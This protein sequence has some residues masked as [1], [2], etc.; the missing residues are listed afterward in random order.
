LNRII[1]LYL[2]SAQ[3]LMARMDA[4][5]AQSDAH[6]MAEAAHSLKSSSAN[7]GARRLAAECLK[8]EEAGRRAEP[9]ERLGKPYRAVTEEYPRVVAALRQVLEA[10]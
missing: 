9:P 3:T 7:L 8:L 1:R 10:G 4:A 2:N 5:I 6:G